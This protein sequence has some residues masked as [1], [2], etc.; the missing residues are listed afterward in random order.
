MFTDRLKTLIDEQCNGKQSVL[1][2][3]SGLPKTVISSYFCRGSQPS[4]SQL[5]ALSQSLNCSIDYLAGLEP[6][7]EDSIFSVTPAPQLSDEEKELL[8]NFRKLPSGLKIR[9]RA[10]LSGMVEALPAEKLHYRESRPRLSVFLQAIF[11]S[12]PGLPRF[13]PG[14]PPF[15]RLWRPLSGAAAY[16]FYNN[17]LIYAIIYRYYCPK[18]VI[19]CRSLFVTFSVSFSSPANCLF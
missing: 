15:P 4:L 10:Y 11:G 16:S 12:P 7:I 5:V 17:L 3:K 14:L 9:A 6:D 13:N 18:N 2:Q 19:G 1:A 8:E